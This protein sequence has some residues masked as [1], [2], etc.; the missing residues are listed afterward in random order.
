M[1]T[2]KIVILGLTVGI[3]V[4]VVLLIFKD[5]IFGAPECD[6][7]PPPKPCPESPTKPTNNTPGTATP[8]TATPGTTTPE[9]FSNKFYMAK[10]CP[11]GWTDIGTIGLIINDAHKA[12]APF[13]LGAEYQ[14]GWTWMH[15][16]LCFGP[17]DPNNLQGL[18]KFAATGELQVGILSKNSAPLA[19]QAD[20][21]P[22][23]TMGSQYVTNEWTWAHPYL[24]PAADSGGFTFWHPQ[25]FAVTG[26]I[27]SD[28]SSAEKSNLPYSSFPFPRGSGP[29]AGWTWHHPFF[30]KD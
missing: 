4:L 6:K 8:G 28:A 2:S 7:C 26:V 14:A 15:P 12:Q 21:E 19:K 3:I 17:A 27:V 16:H 29:G 20:T 25:H 13:D 18:Y 11:Q 23:I 22:Y 30:V 1:E 5:D 10:T 9:A 24:V